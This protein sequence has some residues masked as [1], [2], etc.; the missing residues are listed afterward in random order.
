MIKIE[1]IKHKFIAGWIINNKYYYRVVNK[2]IALA[3]YFLDS[4][5]SLI[6]KKRKYPEKIEN[7]LVIRLEQIGD[8]ILTTSF[9]RELKKNYRE[10]KITVLCRD[11]TKD[12]FKLIPWVD[13]IVVL[14]TPWLSRNDSDGYLNVLKFIM[15]N[16]KK[17]D[18]VFDLHPDPRN[19]IISKFVGKYTVAYDIKGFK[20]LIDK[21]INWNFKKVEHIVDRYINILKELGLTVEDYNLEIILD[22]NIMHNVKKKLNKICNLN[23]NKKLI[24]IHPLSGRLEKNISWEKWK[25]IIRNELVN[26]KNIIFIGG[27]K[28]DKSIIDKNL[29][30]V[31]DDNR[32]Y[33]IA[34]VFNLLEYIHF[35]SLVD[36]IYSVDTF[37]VHVSSALKKRIKTFYIATNEEEWGY[38]QNKH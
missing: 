18:L 34:G 26:E 12:L 22:D 30:D 21:P 11:V 37:V 27:S 33:N 1:K 25:D 13:E 19:L 8:V 38:Y 2:N 15:K 16:Y 5:F 28:Q 3:L 29:K 4:V 20:F 35:I 36:Y 24:L 32:V 10:A 23:G 31:L 14:N 6:F 7:I 9:F 17:Y